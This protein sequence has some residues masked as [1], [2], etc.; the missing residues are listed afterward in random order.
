MMPEEELLHTR[1]YDV[2]T[3][4]VT[5][6]QIR[7]IGTVDDAKPP[8][9]YIEGDPESLGIHR[10]TVDLLLSYPS[11]VIEEAT[12]EFQT[13]PAETCPSI[14]PTYQ[15]LVGLSIARGFARKVNELFGAQRGCT[16]IGALLKAMAP[17]AVQT[18]YSMQMSESKVPVR[19]IQPDDDEATLQQALEFTVNSCH[20]W[21]EEGEA[22]STIL[23]GGTREA[24]VWIAQRLRKL[25]RED[26]IEEWTR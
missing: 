19:W 3:Y 22:V 7:L 16:H 13:N 9:L 4:K 23:N 11:L 20:V 15:Q 25:G 18:I 14:E 21:D 26:Q 12:V 8:G 6:E 2:R 1:T 24:P 5:S 10:M 17:V